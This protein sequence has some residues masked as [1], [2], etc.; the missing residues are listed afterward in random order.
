MLYYN[1]GRV[2]NEHESWGN[3]FIDN[4][5]AD[6]KLS[7][8]N[9]TEYSVKNLNYMAKFVATYSDEDF[10]Q[11]LYAQSPW[12]YNVALLDNF[13]CEAIDYIYE[14]FCN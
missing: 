14:L 6:I 12:S 9:T 3:K 8:P 7:F 4:L 1:I 13:A 5:A 11:T 10:V 2:V